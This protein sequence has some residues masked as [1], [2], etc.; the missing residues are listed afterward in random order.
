MDGVTQIGRARN[1][2]NALVQEPIIVHVDD[3]DLLDP[4]YAATMCERLG[5]ADVCKLDV[6][7]LIRDDDSVIFEWDTRTLGGQHYAMKGDVVEPIVIDPKEMTPEEY[8]A[9]QGAWHDGFGWSMV[10]LRSMWEKVKFAVEGTEDIDWIRRVR[11]AGG[12][13]GS[14]ATCRTSR[15]T[16]CMSIRITAKAAARTFRS[17]CLASCRGQ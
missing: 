8:Q 2:L 4:T 7:R 15:C 5:D 1:E 13:S 3:D 17:G 11:A 10:Y 16:R 9:W 6:W 14:S 12:R